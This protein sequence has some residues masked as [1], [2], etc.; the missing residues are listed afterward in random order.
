MFGKTF[1][2]YSIPRA[3]IHRYAFDTINTTFQI[4]R[5]FDR[6][7]SARFRILEENNTRRNIGLKVPK[8]PK[9]SKMPKVPLNPPYYNPPA[10]L[11]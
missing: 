1:W 10:P 11:W 4:F 8:V 7:L 5:R 2:K 3:G 9:V 6:N